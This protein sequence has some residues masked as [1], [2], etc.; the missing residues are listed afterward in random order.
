MS[1][2]AIPRLRINSGALPISSI[3]WLPA[4][5]PTKTRKEPGREASALARDE[6]LTR[7][8]AIKRIADGL[9]GT[10]V[11]VVAGMIS[12]VTGTHRSHLREVQDGAI[13]YG[14]IIVYKDS[15][16]NKS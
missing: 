9:A 16:K 10:G 14:D 2:M 5:R 6:V 12:Q 8:T 13:V 15:I 11:L 7:R 3:L 4:G 1:P